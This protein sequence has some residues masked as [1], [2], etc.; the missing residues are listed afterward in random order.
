MLMLCLIWW[1]DT[2]STSM[3]CN[4]WIFVLLLFRSTV[5]RDHRLILQGIL[6]NYLIFIHLSKRKGDILNCWNMLLTAI[7]IFCCLEELHFLDPTWQEVRWWLEKGNCTHL[8][9]FTRKGQVSQVWRKKLL[10]LV[11]GIFYL[12]YLSWWSNLVICWSI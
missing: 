7:S 5:F 4:L 6:V 9:S 12:W 2:F 3:L 1:A 10:Y 11:H 8:W